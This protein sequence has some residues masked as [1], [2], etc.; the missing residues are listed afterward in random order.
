[1]PG[2]ELNKLLN[3]LT[4]AA[5]VMGVETGQI[6]LWNHAATGMFGYAPEEAIGRPVT[7]L[8]PPEMQARHDA[9][10]DAYRKTGH[11][12]LIDSGRPLEVT[13]LRRSG[14]RFAIELTLSRWDE[15]YLPG[16]Y[17]LALIRDVSERYRAADRLRKSE[18][19]LA[20]AQQLARLGWWEWD[21]R[22][23]HVEWSDELYRIMGRDRR[24]LVASVDAF[25]S[26]VHPEDRPTVRRTL[27][28]S[29]KNHQPFVYQARIVRPN[30]AIR[31]IQAHGQLEVAATDQLPVRMLGTVQDVT[32]QLEVEYALRRSNALL[33]AQQEAAIDGILVVDERGEVAG[34]NQRFAELWRLDETVMAQHSLQAIL[35]AIRPQFVDGTG[36]LERL[37]YLNEAPSE[38][39]R[40][41]IVLRDGRVFDEYTA[42]AH[43]KQGEYFG[44]VWYLRD[45]TA[46]KQMEEA[47]QESERRFRAIFE[48]A[49]IGIDI[50][51]PD[52]HI[53]E[54]N[55]A[56]QDILGYSAEE[57]QCFRFEELTHPDDVA[58]SKQLFQ[59]LVTGQRDYYKLEKRYIRKDGRVIWANL[60]VYLIRRQAP[61]PSLVMAITED[62]S[63]RKRLEETLRQ[64]Y[65]QLKALDQLKNDFVNA[66]SHDLRTPLTAIF[67]Y[68]EFL[69]DAMGGPLTPQ[70]REF[71]RQIHKNGKRLEWLV[72]DL[73]DVAR[74]EAGTFRLNR[75]IF[76]I[77]AR[78]HDA[79]DA[80]LP[81]VEAAKLHLELA[82]PDGPLMANLD[83][84]RIERVLFN[85]L[86]NAIK[87]TP[88]EGT[89]RVAATPQ[90]GDLYCA[91]TDTGVG[92]PPEDLP[93][94]FR[95]FSQ[96]DQGQRKKGGTGLGL[97]IS[98]SI[99]E[100]HGGTI[101]VSS[102]LG[103][104]S[105]FWF[106][107][108]LGIPP[109]PPAP[110]RLS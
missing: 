107:V 105:T 72:N 26:L 27:D 18:A 14:E 92:I 51:T 34:F 28:A 33:K 50:L 96:L 67:G 99:V 24:T 54:A 65:E 76:D 77:G 48:G 41:E 31:T 102:K 89:I 25:L 46:R 63:E 23:D 17:V 108:P 15:I 70:Q 82:L 7:M 38:A 88:A 45:I 39:S 37:L 84:E 56:L 106:R 86:G 9:G 44:R 8:M 80:F 36:H 98:K 97:S 91:V 13:A 40:E 10:L 83:P 109:A 64:Q 49:G 3:K 42:P 35:E 5:I 47:L 73:L 55:R 75:E 60:T 68:T 95:R 62:V 110:E 103:A 1:M 87:F 29:L 11:G 53:T 30:G 61:A 79:V 85:L 93:R 12:A 90:A 43:S 104:G 6:V 57:L 78:L 71:V 32:E 22:R 69:E 19:R 4:D 59:E 20:E 66:V 58:I 101:G 74:L 100:A 52:G 21:L 16:D 94:L 81:Q 2:S